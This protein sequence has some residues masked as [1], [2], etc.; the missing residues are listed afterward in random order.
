MSSSTTSEA[1]I[2]LLVSP[3]TKQTLEAAATLKELPLDTYLIKLA[4]ETA[5]REIAD[6]ERLVLSDR[7]RDLFLDA[8]DNPP[9]PSPALVSAA[10]KFQTKYGQGHS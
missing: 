7:D 5:K 10:E 8:L 3:E 9:E 6:H 1:R 4:L 2:E